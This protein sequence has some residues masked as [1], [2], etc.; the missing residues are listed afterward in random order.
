[1]EHANY[2]ID[3]VDEAGN[4][5]STKP[6]RDVQKATDLFHT[7]FVIVAT[8]EGQVALSKIPERTDLPNLYIHK[9]GATVATIRRHGENA[10]AAAVRA[11]QTE[12]H[13]SEPV[14]EKLG[15]SFETFSDG[16]RKYISV[17]REVSSLLEDFSRTDIEDLQM[18]DPAGL[19]RAMHDQPEAFA[20]TFA[21]VWQKYGEAF[22][23]QV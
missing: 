2:P 6:R 19:S 8:P 17:Y 14:P 15:E 12:L 9:L 23:P 3:I 22:S 7:I 18:V 4:I 10:D 21:M 1:M 20:P 16:T 11:L 13:M 5:L